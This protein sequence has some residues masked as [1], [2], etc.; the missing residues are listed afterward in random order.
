MVASRIFCG[1]LCGL[2]VAANARA[3]PVVTE[4]A[5]KVKREA[6]KGWPEAV[7]RMRWWE[8]AGGAALLG[9]SLAIRF[10]VDVSGEPTWKNGNAFDDAVY[11]AVLIESP[12]RYDAWRTV[13]D[14]AYYSGF[15]WAVL[16]PL[17]AGI[18]Y[19][20]GTALQMTMMNLE[21]FSVYSMILNVS[22]A[23][24]RRERPVRRECADPVK[25]NALQV[26]CADD[27]PDANRS[28]IGGHTG[29]VATSAT[30]TCI[31]HA[32]IRL[33]GSPGADALPCVT[34]AAMTATVFTSRT[35]TGRHALSDNLL[36][37]GV[38]VFSGLVPWALHYAIPKFEGHAAD[39]AV[40]R[41]T[42]ALVV[43]T[44]RG[45]SLQLSGVLF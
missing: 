40:A 44:D 14:L 35:L 24:V 34:M 7:P 16:D 2:L 25:A 41:P 38:G 15:T 32:N 26:N 6:K 42:G 43:P 11:E 13:G 22:Q 27:S 4:S 18:A 45:F 1:A 21:A 20:W 3:D 5:P 36:G 29:T 33:W 9:G 39:S 37:V 31:H 17:I 12:F 19:D 30:L 23:I 8:Y 28:F 10:A